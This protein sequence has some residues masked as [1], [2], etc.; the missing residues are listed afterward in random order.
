MLVLY[1]L[2]TAALSILLTLYCI[3]RPL[4][5]IWKNKTV[6]YVNKPFKPRT[7]QLVRRRKMRRRIRAL[8]TSSSSGYEPSTSGGANRESD[9]TDQRSRP[10]PGPSTSSPAYH[11]WG[12]HGLND[13]GH[14]E[15]EVP[16]PSYASLRR[17]SASSGSSAHTVPLRGNSEEKQPLLFQGE[18][19]DSE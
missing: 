13:M 2:L 14:S 7:N 15:E 19:S 4:Q 6:K 11:R 17:T 10:P 8:D 3:Q 18:S 5:L 1:L 12:R 9:T 16:P